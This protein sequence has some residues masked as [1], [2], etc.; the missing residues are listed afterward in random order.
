MSRCV[1]IKLTHYQAATG[2]DD[3]VTVT[4]RRGAGDDFQRRRC[5]ANRLVVDTG[6]R[7]DAVSRRSVGVCGQDG[8]DHCGGFRGGTRIDEGLCEC[9]V[10]RP[11]IRMLI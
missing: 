5:L 7:C 9:S 6:I 3:G 10:V 4:P 2:A 1:Q 8:C 11:R